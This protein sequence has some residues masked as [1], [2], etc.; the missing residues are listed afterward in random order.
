MPETK[1]STFHDTGRKMGEAYES[2]VSVEKDRI[3]YPSF[4]LDANK[5]PELKN[6]DVGK[7]VQLTV[8]GVVKRKSIHESN[9]R[10]SYDVDVEVRAVSVANPKSKKFSQEAIDASAKGAK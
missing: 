1:D 4:S 9:D 7:S 2:P 5:I 6:A 8:K 10:N 3:M